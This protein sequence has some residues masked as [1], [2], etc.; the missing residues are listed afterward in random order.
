[1]RFHILG[2]G[3]SGM[4]LAWYLSEM[5]QNVSVIEKDKWVGGLAK[6]RKSLGK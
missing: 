4:A 2:G 1:M 6:S 5:G 3:P